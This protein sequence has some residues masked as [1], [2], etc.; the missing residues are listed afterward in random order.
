MGSDPKAKNLHYFDG[1]IDLRSIIWMQSPATA[2]RTG[3]PAIWRL[4]TAGS[5]RRMLQPS[6]SG[7]RIS[8]SEGYSVNSGP[9]AP[10]PLRIAP[11]AA[12]AAALDAL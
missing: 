9:K 12:G 6:A 1:A 11:C 3:A 8:P 7:Q 2:D 10:A 4:V 5:R